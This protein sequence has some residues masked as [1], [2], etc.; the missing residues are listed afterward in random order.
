METNEM[1]QFNDGMIIWNGFGI[2]KQL[3]LCRLV[4]IV[5]IQK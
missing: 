5:F 2:F 4:K 1:L 3:I